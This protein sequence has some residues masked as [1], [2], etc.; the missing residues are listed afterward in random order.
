MHMCSH[1]SCLI[2]LASC[3]LILNLVFLFRSFKPKSSNRAH[4]TFIS[5]RF[6]PNRVF[7]FC[8]F[9]LRLQRTNFATYFWFRIFFFFLI[10]KA[11]KTVSISSS[12]LSFSISPSLFISFYLFEWKTFPRWSSINNSLC[13]ACTR[14]FALF[15]CLLKTGFGPF[16]EKLHEFNDFTGN[17]ARQSSSRA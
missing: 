13:K 14:E 12:G 15:E 17:I 11:I 4:T 9:L 10:F 1:I 6:N 5:I 16:Y 7:T 8:K 2:F 3:Q